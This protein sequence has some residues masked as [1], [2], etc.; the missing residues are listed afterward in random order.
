MRSEVNNPQRTQD[1]D[2]DQPPKKADETPRREGGDDAI[3]E[4]NPTD[5]RLDEKVIVNEQRE[6]KIVNTPSQ[7]AV[8]SSESTGTD[9]DA[10][11]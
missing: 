1:N 7:T 8:N 9:E 6:N 5:S 4:S 3:A 10:I 2:P 11:N